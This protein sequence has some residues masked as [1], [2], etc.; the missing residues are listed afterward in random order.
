DGD[1]DTGGTTVACASL[2]FA[3]PVPASAYV[4]SLHDALPISGSVTFSVW[5]GKQTCTGAASFTATVALDGSGNADPALPKVVPVGG[6]A[7]QGHYLGSTTYNESTSD[8]EPLD[9]SKLDSNSTTAIHSGA[10][11][12]GGTT[13]VTHAPIGSTVHDSAHVTGTAAGGTPTGSVTFSVWLG[14]TTC[15]ADPAATPPDATATVTLNGSGNADPVLPKV[16][17]VG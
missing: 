3:A 11:D 6:L 1:D 13:V 8:C 16:V 14:R 7:Y 9:A 17:P 5:L 4:L 10:N 15:P 2:P 12:T